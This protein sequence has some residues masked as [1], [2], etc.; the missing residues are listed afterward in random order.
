MDGKVITGWNGLAIAA[1]ARAGAALGEE[2]WIEAAEGAA[3]E[4]LQTNRGD[5][6]ELVRSSLDGVASGAVAT[7]ADLGLFAEGLLALAAATGDSAW[8]SSAID[9]L[10]RALAGVGGDPVLIAQ[11]V[12]P[13]PDQTDGDLPSGAA[14]VASA[15]LAAWRLGAGERY[16]QA[17]AAAV[18]AL[19]ARALEQPFAHGSLLRVAAGL[20]EPPRQVVVVTSDRSGPLARAVRGIDADVIAVVTPPQAAA[21]AEAGFA[22]FEGKAEQPE[23][24]YD[25]RAFACRLPF[26]DPGQVAVGR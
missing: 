3:S 22:L 24:V 10:D 5:G 18:R 26:G 8:A 23:L 2:T 20:A 6:G 14:A 9:V 13:A 7:V 15:A 12:T 1:L 17:A 21:F 11:G 25:C 16:R 4:V 19:G